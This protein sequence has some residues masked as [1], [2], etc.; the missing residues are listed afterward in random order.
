MNKMKKILCMLIVFAMA[1]P[2]I[3]ISAY[4]E[5]VPFEVTAVVDYDTS[6]LTI[7]VTT[8]AKYVQ[9]I[10][11]VMYEKY[12][13]DNV[14]EA[15]ASLSNILRAVTVNANGGKA[16][17]T[18]QLDADDPAGYITISAAGSGSKASVSKDTTDIYFESQTYINEVTLPAI[19]S[20]TSSNIGQLLDEKADMLQIDRTDL[21][22]NEDEICDLFLNIREVD[23]DNTCEDMSDVVEILQGVA[24]IRA[25]D[26]AVDADACEVLCEGE[27][28]L[29]T[30]DTENSDY[31]SKKDDVY[32]L[33]YR[34]INNE[35]PTSITDVKN[36]L[37]QSVAIANFNSLNATNIG[38][39]VEEYIEYFGITSEDYNE[40]C[41]KYGAS[42]I[43]KT[44]VGR[45][46]TLPSQVVEAFNDVVDNAEEES[47]SSGGGGGGGTIGS[48]P[49]KD[50][51]EEV[52]ADQ[53]LMN[54]PANEELLPQLPVGSLFN[55]VPKTHWAHSAVNALHSL[56]VIDGIASNIFDPD[57]FVTREQF[58][59]MLVM[60]FDIY[61]GNALTIFTDLMGHW[62]NTY[63][64]SAHVFGVVNGIDNAT[65][66]VGMPITRQDAAVMLYRLI[67][68]K[69]I[70]LEV[71]N[72]AKVF[73]DNAQIADYASE[74]VTKLNQAGIINGVSDTEFR[75]TASLTRAQAAQLI[76]GAVSR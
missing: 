37:F 63:V 22:E 62:S 9:K 70:E 64:A 47:G 27:A 43:N 21:A 56:G 15:T 52:S 18:I 20:A 53:D 73:E 4:A 33:F 46:F 71:V 38:P 67:D 48:R 12:E 65:F 3:C 1:I 72:E 30:L 41:E 60:A 11:I 14:T 7:N 10:S 51:K 57:S 59:K 50:D 23:Y 61:D 68:K 39:M 19:E 5:E 32:D 58:V 6:V 34:N 31:T 16:S 75:P 25:L 40:A 74:S 69:G 17:T 29:L 2:G 35:M 28:T 45:D 66:G 24:L 76:Y 44:F 13:E 55:D 42:E 26:D 54:K 8:P 36:D 49:S